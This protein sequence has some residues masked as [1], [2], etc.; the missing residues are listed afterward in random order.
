MPAHPPTS[1]RAR[2]L[3]GYG[4]ILMLLDR[5]TES[6]ALC[7]QAV[8]MAREVGA[9]QVEE[10]FMT[11]ASPGV[12]AN[13]LPNAYY[14]TEEAYLSALAEVMKEIGLKK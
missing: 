9:R 6:L 4:Q 14:P 13:F 1:E 5:W 3:S 8:A 12:I 2:V 11:A 7:E 10:V